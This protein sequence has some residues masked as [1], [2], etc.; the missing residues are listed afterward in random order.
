MKRILFGGILTA[1]LI[2]WQPGSARLA[3]EKIPIAWKTVADF[4]VLK[5]WEEPSLGPKE[6]QIALLQL[7]VDRQKE[8]QSDPLAFYK[9]YEIFK[10]SYSDL[11]KGQ[12]VV[13]LGESKSASD[14]PYFAV[15]VH[16]S[17]TYSASASFGV[18]AIK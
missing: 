16:D 12:F 15:V 1:F 8:L 2:L 3:Q 18:D 11:S 6:P 17:H 5:L 10:P 14:D 9:K 7:S 13:Q 4:K